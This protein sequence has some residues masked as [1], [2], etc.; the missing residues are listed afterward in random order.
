[1]L[2]GRLGSISV[3][4]IGLAVHYCL[5][6]MFF[7]ILDNWLEEII[8]KLIYS[9]TRSTTRRGF[10]SSHKF[11]IVLRW[12]VYFRQHTYGWSPQF[13]PYQFQERI[14]FWVNLPFVFMLPALK[15]DSLV[16]H[17]F[18]MFGHEMLLDSWYII[19]PVWNKNCAPFI[20][21]FHNNV[22]IIYI[23]TAQVSPCRKDSIWYFEFVIS[24]ARI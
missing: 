2:E 7:F 17:V 18:I 20:R 6:Y 16:K 14:C 9:L 4:S 11:L 10:G 15:L 5:S 23:E 12:F 22:L 8:R 19:L 13:F 3:F 24:L 21:W 1:M